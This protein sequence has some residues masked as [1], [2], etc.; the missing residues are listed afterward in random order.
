MFA[1]FTLSK[2][3]LDRD[4][5]NVAAY[6]QSWIKALNSDRK[7]I[8]VAAREAKKAVEYFESGKLPGST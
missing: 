3:G 8:I 6:I 1:G 2:V 5:K 7:A 4:I